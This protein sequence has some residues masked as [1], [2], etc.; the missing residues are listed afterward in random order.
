MK[1]DKNG[2][3]LTCVYCGQEYPQNTPA[4]GDKVLTDHIKICPKHPMRKAEKNIELLRNALIGLVGADTKEELE[5]M[6]SFTRIAPVPEKD[7]TSAIN[8]IHAL[9]D[10]MP[11]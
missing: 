11:E 9:L 7:K 6:E 3:I 4:W 5:Q 8:A 2:R 10:T 1:M